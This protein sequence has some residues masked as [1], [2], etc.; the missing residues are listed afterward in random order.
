MRWS[1][2]TIGTRYPPVA[3]K[4]IPCDECGHRD[5]S[6]D[7]QCWRHPQWEGKHPD[8]PGVHRFA[9]GAVRSADADDVRYDLITPI[10]LEAVARTCAEGAKKYGERNWE[11]GMPVAVML[12]HAL[13]HIFKFLLGDRSEDHLAHAAWNLLG[14]IHSDKMW[15]ELNGKPE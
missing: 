13:R 14:A 8:T 9:T 7:D 1:P 12:N 2:Q 10:G 5:G 15:P 4:P 3:D 6:H 11:K